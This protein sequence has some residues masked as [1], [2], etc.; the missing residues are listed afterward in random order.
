MCDGGRELCTVSAVTVRG[1]GWERGIMY[2]FGTH[3]AGTGGWEM[4]IMYCD[5]SYV[6]KTMTHHPTQ[7]SGIRLRNLHGGYSLYIFAR[8]YSRK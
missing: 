4:G 8:V 7:L 3:G 5:R 6:F 1:V 2:C